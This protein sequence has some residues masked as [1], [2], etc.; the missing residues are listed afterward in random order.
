MMMQAT[1]DTDLAAM[2]LLA[3]LEQT[4]SIVVQLN[5]KR[6]TLHA[7]QI[8]FR[9]SPAKRKVIRAG[10]R[11]G[12]TV[13][14]ADIAISA[15]CAGRRVLYASPTADQ[16]D[17]FW[18]EV[19]HAFASDIEA[20]RLYRNEVR[21]TLE[22]PNTLKRIRAKTA[23]NADTLRG[24]YADLIIL[25]EWQLMNED[26][27]GLVGAPMLLDN[28][29]DSIFVY[30]PPSARSRS[31][32]KATDKLHAA[33]LF[34]RASQ[35]TS[36]R[37]KTFHFRS[38]DNPHI[39]AEAIANLAHD[40]TAL[41][42]RQEI[43]AEDVEDVPGA[44]WKQSKIDSL[45]VTSAPKLKRVVV[46]ID[47]SATKTGNEAGV[48]VAGSGYDNHG[49]LLDDRS[50]QGSPEEWAKASVDGYHLFEAD[51]IVAE[52]NN[53]GE[54][55]E[56]TIR[57]IKGA[58]AVKRIHATRGKRTRAEPIS[59]LTDQNRIHHVGVFA[60]LESE[61][62]TWVTGDESP[63][64]LDAYV[65]AFTE[66]MLD[67]SGEMGNNQPTQPSRWMERGNGDGDTERDDSGR[68]KR[69]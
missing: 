65:W 11:G 40:M 52:D 18:W 56:V 26:A 66:L 32:S 20:G 38:H 57:T 35:D 60:P 33:K 45:R 21:H 47:P 36:G 48:I 39:S 23:W 10:R 9:D 4:T 12:K 6:R 31:T 53:G 8:E 13:G 7:K 62:T 54:M 67:A 28:D 43:F 15:L 30:S 68:W 3:A 69:Y 29:G 55:V 19:T 25:D 34:K 42:I 1:T 59:I 17:A 44:L 58:P 49:Y 27:W 50:L 64:R 41:A 24:D 51:I 63:N 22:V 2:L 16:L 14:V 61:L 37:W 5:P 46:A